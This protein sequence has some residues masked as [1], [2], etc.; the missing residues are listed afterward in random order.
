MTLGAHLCHKLPP[1]RP[2]RST[3]QWLRSNQSLLLLILPLQLLC[4]LRLLVCLL[5]QVVATDST[6]CLLR[7]WLR[8][9]LVCLL[10]TTKHCLFYP[11]LTNHTVLEI[12]LTC[13]IFSEKRNGWAVSLITNI[14]RLIFLNIIIIIILFFMLES[15]IN[16]HDN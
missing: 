8:R 6:S 10:G 3:K 13:L 16:D 1:T 5:T 7:Q 15:L 14:L 4:H 12:E 2:D 11:H 9:H